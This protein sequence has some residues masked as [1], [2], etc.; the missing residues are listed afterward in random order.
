MKIVW[1]Y[2]IILNVVVTICC[3]ALLKMHSQVIAL[4]SKVYNLEQMMI[5]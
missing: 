5:D 2:I 3:S 4:E 1:L